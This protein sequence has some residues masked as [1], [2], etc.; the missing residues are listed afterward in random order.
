MKDTNAIRTFVTLLERQAMLIDELAEREADL[1]KLVTARAWDEL[2]TLIPHMTDLGEAINDAEEARSAVY[3]E[4]VAAVGGERSFAHILSRLPIEVRAALSGAYRRLKVAVLRLQ[5]RTSSVDTYLGS[6]I[7]T[8]RG[9]LRELYP[10]HA[11]VGYS[12]N[13][14]NRFGNGAPVMVDRAL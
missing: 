9:V 13:G 14:R 5:S 11:S 12:R 8:T 4:I 6:T 7:S 3:D 10:E 1:Q 2:E